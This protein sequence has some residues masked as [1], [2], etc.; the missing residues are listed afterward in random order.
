MTKNKTVK[1]WGLEKDTG[2]VMK[3]VD[4]SVSKTKIRDEIRKITTG[5]SPDGATSISYLG[6]EDIGRIVNLCRSWALKTFKDY[7]FYAGEWHNAGC[8]FIRSDR[9]VCCCNHKKILKK[10]REGGK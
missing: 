9:G 10:I 1:V 7:W 3:D 5:H 4:V 8:A 6:E 2:L